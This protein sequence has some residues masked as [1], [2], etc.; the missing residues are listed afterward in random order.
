MKRWFI[1][2]SLL[3]LAGSCFAQSEADADKAGNVFEK[4]RN[5]FADRIARREGDILTIIISESTTGSLGATTTLTKSDTNSVNQ[6]IPILQG[7]FSSLSAGATSNVAGTGA[8]TA[9]GS[10]TAQMTVTVKK[11][12]PNGNLVIEGV[13]AIRMNKDLQTYRLDGVV[14]PDDIQPDNTIA[15]SKIA[16][17]KITLDGKGAIADRQRRGILTRILDWLF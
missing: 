12:M 11:V 17:A 10:L 4:Y 1:P 3:V 2:G 5:P 8:T 15:S 9:N 13:R 14:R 16:D 7:L 6:A